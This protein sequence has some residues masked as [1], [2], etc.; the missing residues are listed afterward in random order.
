MPR[1]Y[2]IDLRERV[3]AAYEAGAGSQAEVA[4]R[5]RVGERTLSS[6]LKAAR[7]AGRRAPKPRARGPAPLG[8]EGAAPTAPVAEQSDATL[9]E[10]ALRLAE[11]TGVRR[12]PATLCRA[13]T[14]LGLVRKKRRSEPP[15]RIARTWPRRGRGGT[16]SWP[17]SDLS[18][19]SSSTRPASTPGQRGP[20]R[21]PRADSQRAP[22]KAPWGHWERLTVIGALA[23]ARRR[24]GEHERRGGDRHRG[25]VPGLRGTGTGAGAAGPARGH[26][27]DGHWTAALSRPAHKAEA[28]RAGLDRVGLGHCYLP[29]Y[30]PDSNPIEPAWS[31]LK[32][33]L[34]TKGA[35]ARAKRSTPRSARRSARSLPRMPAAGSA[36][37]AMAP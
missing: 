37:A 6:W 11:R 22:G 5:Y 8:G 13:L 9:A 24:R 30:S 29:P 35:P 32:A 14:R 18:A 31:K 25:G 20:T 26:C 34:R 12:S 15:S 19:W 23:R 1:P 4:R 10:H 27:G 28:V 36:S 21:A 33:R 7:G 2:S 16:P 3:L 17:A